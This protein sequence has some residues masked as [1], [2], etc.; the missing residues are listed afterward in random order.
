MKHEETGDTLDADWT[1]S[2]FS[3]GEYAQD[4]NPMLGEMPHHP[5][6][7]KVVDAATQTTAPEFA[8]WTNVGIAVAGVGL[9]TQLCPH[10]YHREKAKFVVN[11][12][13]PSVTQNGVITAA[14][15]G[16]VYIGTGSPVGQVGASQYLTGFS[17]ELAGPDAN[18]VTFTVS[19][20]ATPSAY[21]LP[22]GQTQMTV[23]FPTPVLTNTTTPRVSWTATATQTGEIDLYGT[24]APILYIANKQ[25]PLTSGALQNVFFIQPGQ[26]IP[27][28]EGQQEV[29]AICSQAGV[30]VNILDMTYGTVQ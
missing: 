23:T 3:E 26:M 22:A 11:W 25:A 27:D 9:P 10:K 28:Y 29:W 21:I 7:V 13:N 16:F 15:P 20:T 6:H 4:E 24:N 1:E 30:E 8:A 5:L 17:V 19:G 2:P 14:V 18:P 12:G